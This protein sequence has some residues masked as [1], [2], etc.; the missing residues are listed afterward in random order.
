MAGELDNRG[1]WAD[2]KGGEATPQATEGASCLTLQSPAAGDRRT[3]LGEL[4]P[5]TG[6]MG[7]SGEDLGALGILGG[8]LCQV[9][10]D[11]GTKHWVT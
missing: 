4:L 2:F 3:H 6:K 9:S 10:E 1:S 11:I 7:H 5:G 8:V